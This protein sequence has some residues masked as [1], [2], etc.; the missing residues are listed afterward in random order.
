[1]LYHQLLIQWFC[2]FFRIIYWSASSTKDSAFHKK[3]IWFWPNDKDKLTEK[4][5]KKSPDG[6]ESKENDKFDQSSLDEGNVVR[7]VSKF[8][9]NLDEIDEVL[10]NG[11]V[12]GTYS[13]LYFCAFKSS[14]VVVSSG[15]L[16]LII[17]NFLQNLKSC[18]KTLEIWQKISLK[19]LSLYE[20][21]GSWRWY[22]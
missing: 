20:K 17:Q 8:G 19:H 2:R 1:M 18:R 5:E 3:N 4:N 7:K 10:E 21:D 11:L 13:N 9:Q 16:L 22:R 12:K 14:K 15:C 6:D